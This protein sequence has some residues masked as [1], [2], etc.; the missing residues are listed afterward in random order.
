MKFLDYNGLQ[1]FWSK[2]KALFQS[3]QDTLVSGT[4]IKTINNES[5]LGSGN[6]QAG[7]PDAVK[8]VS[9]T[10][11][12]A[13][14]AQARTNI[15]AVGPHTV[16]SK[17]DGTVDIT[18]T[19]GDTITVDLNHEHPQYNSKLAEST[20]PSGGFL[21]DMVYILGELSGSVTFSLASA[22]MGN[23]NHYYWTF[24]TGA[25]VPSITFPTGITWA[26]GSEPA[27]LANKHYEISILGGI[28]YYSEV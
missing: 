14:K 6:I 8:Y 10:L 27:V 13:Q 23:I 26:A 3:K 21:P 25:S 19:N 9:Q 18:L 4:N 1:Y 2:L 15:G 12:E 22:V 16:S 28:A 24:S 17:Q 20:Q 5:I 11:T 7:D